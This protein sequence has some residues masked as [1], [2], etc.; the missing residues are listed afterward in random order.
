MSRRRPAHAP[1]PTSP[2]AR[3]APVALAAGLV[4]TGCSATNPMLTQLDYNASDG[5][6]LQVGDVRGINL[7]V[8]TAAE[9]EPGVLVGALTNEDDE[10]VTVEISVSGEDGA[11]TDPVRVE[12]PAGGTVSF[13]GA[14]STEGRVQAEEVEL[15]AVPARP[16]AHVTLEVRVGTGESVTRRVPVLDGTLEPYDELLPSGDA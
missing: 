9:G 1:R 7:F 11:S 3:L 2:V 15:D 12:V 16:G 4:L 5:L 13:A 6:D 14:E 10:D 8:V